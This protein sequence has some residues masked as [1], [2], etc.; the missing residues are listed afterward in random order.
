MN[1]QHSY[2]AHG[3]YTVTVTVRD[4]D[5]AAAEDHFTVY[6]NTAPIAGNDSY[7]IKAGQTFALEQGDLL[8]NDHDADGDALQ[9]VSYSQPTV[10]TLVLSA[11]RFQYTPLAGFVGSDSFTY[12][13]TDGVQ[14]LPPRSPFPSSTRRLS[15]VTMSTVWRK[16]LR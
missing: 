12:T 7:T 11:D 15:P 5:G 14:R 9:V 1:G 16:T 8:Q 10:G 4:N 13:I 3:D 6:V 2:A